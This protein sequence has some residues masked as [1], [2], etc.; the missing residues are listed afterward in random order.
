[1]KAKRKRREREKRK[2]RGRGRCMWKEESERGKRGTR[3]RRREK[4]REKGGK[5]EDMVW[6]CGVGLGY[7][8]WGV[9]YGNYL[10]MPN[11]TIHVQYNS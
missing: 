9:K 6:E 1:M 5:I 8:V 7:G 10:P 11:P 2:D 4:R 3:R